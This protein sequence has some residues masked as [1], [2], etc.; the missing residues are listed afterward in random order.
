MNIV[1]D[2]KSF[3]TKLYLSAFI[4]IVFY[5]LYLTVPDSEFNNVSKSNCKLDR[6]YYTIATHTGKRDND[7]LKPVSLRVKILSI[8]HMLLAYSIII[9]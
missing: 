4:V 6:I 7:T 5:L 9:L 1:F 3:T 8:L 2:L